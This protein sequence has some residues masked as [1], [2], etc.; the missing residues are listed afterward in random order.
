MKRIALATLGVGLL[1]ATTAFAADE[2]KGHPG[3]GGAQ[4][5][6]PHGSSA[7]HVGGGSPHASGGMQ[8]ENL[9]A[10]RANFTHHENFNSAP[11][12]TFTRD[13]RSGTTVRTQERNRGTT[14]GNREEQNRHVTTERHGVSGAQNTERLGTR[15]SNWNNRPRTFNRSTYQRNATSARRFH[16]GSYSRPAGWYYRRWSY[17]QFLP[18]AFWVR[19]YWLTDWWLFDLPIPPYGYEWVRYGA[20]ALLVN[21]YTGEILEVEYDVF[22]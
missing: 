21:I 11:S 22:Y 18:P 4:R 16:Y 17:G 20:D 15:P 7:P 8:H 2:N 14:I 19:E 6:A 5:P 12:H 10:P 3:G 13:E 1:L 9:S